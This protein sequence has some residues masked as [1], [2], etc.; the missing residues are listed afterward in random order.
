MQHTNKLHVD[1]FV[2]RYDG[3]SHSANS[4][5]PRLERVDELYL[6]RPHAWTPRYL[7]VDV[8]GAG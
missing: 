2:S 7:H 3:D 1:V 8:D 5:S 6:Q 4:S